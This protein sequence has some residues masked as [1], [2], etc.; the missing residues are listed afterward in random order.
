MHQ[1]HLILRN[2][3]QAEHHGFQRLLLGIVPSGQKGAGHKG[4]GKVVQI[5]GLAVNLVYKPLGYK[6]HQPDAGSVTVRFFRNIQHRNIANAGAGHLGLAL[7]AQAANN[8]GIHTS[9]A[10]IFAHFFHNQAVQPVYRQG[11]HK[12]F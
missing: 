2:A 8:I 5:G 10:E 1:P 9:A 6:V 3:A 4:C 11:G 7:N 12:G